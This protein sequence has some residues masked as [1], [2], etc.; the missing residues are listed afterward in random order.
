MDNKRKAAVEALE[1]VKYLDEDLKKIINNDYLNELEKIKD[2][3]YK[4][5]INKNVPI[6][7]NEFMDETIEMLKKLFN[8]EGN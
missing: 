7:D 2:L 5:E 3:D 1:I 8:Q 4:F 6:Y